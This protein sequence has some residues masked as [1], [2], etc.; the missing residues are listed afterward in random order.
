M[1]EIAD[2]AKEKPEMNHTK[3]LILTKESVIQFSVFLICVLPLFLAV[4]ACTSNPWRVQHVSLSGG[5]YPTRTPPDKIQVFLR[6]SATPSRPHIDVAQVSV[7]QKAF[8]APSF[9][10]LSTESALNRLKVRASEVGADA[11]KEVSILVAPT[12]AVSAGSASVD[13]VAIR[14]K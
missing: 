5:T 9:E 4:S 1:Q 10:H 7:R 14:W 3:A 6:G 2:T 11:V 13:G 12:G 8:H